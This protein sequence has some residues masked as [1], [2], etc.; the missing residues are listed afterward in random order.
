MKIIKCWLLRYWYDWRE[1]RRSQNAENVF[2]SRI[3]LNSTFIDMLLCSAFRWFTGE[4]FP[5]V[6]SVMGTRTL[7]TYSTKQTHWASIKPIM[8]DHSIG[9]RSGRQITSE[10]L[11]VEWEMHQFYQRK[12]VLDL[13]YESIDKTRLDSEIHWCKKY[14]CHNSWPRL[15]VRFTP[16]AINNSILLTILLKSSSVGGVTGECH[17]PSNRIL[18]TYSLIGGGISIRNPMTYWIYWEDYFFISE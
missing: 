1:R 10:Q 14:R 7:A 11:N 12:I 16:V 17:N 4:I 2:S 15:I 6:Q 13:E 18:F 8:I 5:S 9:F 3:D